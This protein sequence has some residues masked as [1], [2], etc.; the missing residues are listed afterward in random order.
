[1]N[2]YIP[3]NKYDRQRT[4]RS[5]DLVKEPNELIPKLD[6]NGILQPCEALHRG[7]DELITGGRHQTGTNSDF[8][9]QKNFTV[10]RFRSQAVSILCHRREV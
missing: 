9:F 2:G 3:A 1:M 5:Q 6:G 4:N 8:F 10:K 7:G